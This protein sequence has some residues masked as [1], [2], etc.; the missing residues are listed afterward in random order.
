MKMLDAINKTTRLICLLLIIGAVSCKKK[1]TLDVNKDLTACGVKD[2]L[3]NLGWLNAEFKLLKGDANTSG[4]ILYNYNGSEVIE[5][6]DA[7]FSSTNQ[8]QYYCDGIKLN[9]DE[10]SDF[11]KFKQERKLIS[12]MYGTNIWK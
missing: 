8:H 3:N 12:V 6:Q 1:T 2:P 9:L 7:V 11:N 10:P 4:I 5:I